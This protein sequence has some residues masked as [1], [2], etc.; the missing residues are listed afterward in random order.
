MGVLRVYVILI[1]VGFCVQIVVVNSQ[2]L[3]CNSNDLKA[4]EGF[5][6]GL[7]SSIDGWK[8]NESS[9]FSS[10]CCDWVGISCKSSVSLGLDDVNESGRVVEL[11]LGRRKLSGKLSESV[12]KLD[13][14]KVLNLTHNSLSGSIAASLLNLSN[15]EVLDLSSN[16]FSG[17]F[18]SLINLP[19]LR[20]LNVYEN[21][22]HGLIP[23]SLCNN[24]PRIREIDLAMNYF[25]GSIPVGIGNCSS[26][27]YLGLA[28]NNL[29]GSI[30][31]ELFQLSNLSV[32][33]LQNNRL[34]GALSS[35]LGKLS[36]LGRL[37]ISSNKFSGK[38]PDVFLELN[39]LWYFSAQSNLFNGE[40]PRS[41]SNSRS[42]SLLSLRNNTLSGQIYLNCSAM[43][44]LT[45]LDLASNSFSGSIPS[46]LPNCLRL[47]TIN[48]AKIKFIAQ[49]P[50]SFKNF[51]SL[52]SLSFSNSSIQN[53]SSALEILQHCQ[54]LKTLVLTLN[55]QKEELPSVPSLQ[56]KNLKVLIIASCQ[57]RGTVP[58]WLSNSPSLQL[59]DL[60]WNQLSGTIPPWLG[61]L[62]SL[63][64]LDLSNNTFIGEIPHSL[65]SLQSL[66]SKENAVEEPSPDFPFFKKKN[67]NAG[68]LQ[69]NQPSSFP[70]MIDLS[71]NSLN[72]S[73]WPEFG[74]L[75]QLH[76][77][78]LKNNNL[79]GNIPA[80][81]SGMTSLEVLDLSHNNLSGNIPPSLVKLSFLSTFSVAYNK[82]S[83]PIP[84]GVQFQTFPN[85][86]FEG[87][88]GLCG[89]H[90]SPCH[91][92]DQSPHGSAV[93]SKKNIRKIVAVAVGTGLGTVFLLTVT[94]LI[95]LRTTSRGEVDPEKKADADEIELGSRSVVLFHNKDSNNEL[96]L[97]DILKS[98][99]SFNQANIIGCGGFG[100]VYKATLPDGTKVAIKRLSGDTGQM[101]REFQAEVETLSRAQH[102]NLVHLLGYCNYK[103]D[104]LLIYSYMDN[105]SLDYWLHEKPHILHRDIKS[106]NILLSDTF[107]AH[108]ADFGL[109]RL[110][111]PYD[112]HVTTDLVGTLGYIPPEYGQA[113]VATYKG[114]VYSFGVVLLELLTGR[115]PM[116]VCKPRGSRDLISWV[117][118]MKTEKRESEIFDPFI[119]DKDHAE[120]MLLV[121]EIACRC[122]GENPKTRPTTQ[123]L[124]SWLE[125]IDVSS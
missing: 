60:S 36:N 125:N 102:P 75:R 70:P 101:D 21:S 85:S 113:S 20:V 6:R 61:S 24:L 47:K 95:I 11:E 119:Y 54:N 10:N 7:E 33:A 30:P 55:F 41:L 76:V 9:S 8:W 59:L 43:T 103:N 1:L 23:A 72:G 28:S 29:S 68:G 108:L 81:L 82:L 107:V 89:E 22:F 35:K 3:T 5:M 4:L 32:L 116:D 56:F 46:N 110:I 26:V 122:L 115:R 12:A 38:I 67:T 66:V 99:S 50:E 65:T 112:T 106:S 86:S 78:N 64:Y 34:S 2:N 37:D 48:F 117:L 13:Q 90:A 57:L 69:Y 27:E 123:Q 71:Y 84:T 19:S 121:L 111:L 77:L 97:D 80:N 39:K 96:S 25:D 62:N 98:T 40:M 52:T 31:Q 120:E 15:L 49:I 74:D 18:P 83:G 94:L 58:Q 105:G 63:F 91:I 73:I 92:T 114:D 118:Q 51:Q 16:D 88:Q 44:N 79:S 100:L 42:I 14:L 93:K 109:A 53:I 45:S 17:L 87:N 104:K 124:V